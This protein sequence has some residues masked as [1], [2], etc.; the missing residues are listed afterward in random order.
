MLQRIGIALLLTSI[1]FILF[2]QVGFCQYPLRWDALH[3]FL[4][5]RHN[6]GES[7]R[8]GSLPLWSAYQYLGFP[9][10]ADPEVGAF[11]PPVWLL[12]GLFGYDFYTLHVEWMFHVIIA[13][14]GMYQL[15]KSLGHSFVIRL[16][17]AISFLASGMYVSNAQNFIYLI[18]I[19]W[20]PLLLYHLRMLSHDLK[21]K[22]VAAIVVV[23]YMMITG[24]YPGITI[25][26]FYC[27][28][29]YGLY[30]LIYHWTTQGTSMIK[31]WSVLGLGVLVVCSAALVSVAQFLSYLSRADGLQANRI[32]ENPLPLKGYISFILPWT[33]GTMENFDWG[34]DLTMINSYVGLIMIIAV[35]SFVFEKPQH[36]RQW[37]MLVSL[38]I[39][40]LIAL[41]EATPLRMW[42][43][44]LPG[45]SLFRHPSIFRFF[46][47]FLLV[48]LGA[49]QLQQ[50]R[51]ET[52]IKGALLI[53]PIIAVILL[54]HWSEFESNALQHLIA[55]WKNPVDHSGVSV[56]SRAVLNGLIALPL[57]FAA[58]IFIKKRMWYGLLTLVVVDLFLATQVNI[59]TMTVYTFPFAESQ[60]KMAQLPQG[61]SPY[62]G[63]LIAH[64]SSDHDSLRIPGI[65]ENQNILQKMPAYDGYN[66]FILKGF[67][68]FE[69]DPSF[70]AEMNHALI[71]TYDSTAVSNWDLMPNQIAGDIAPGAATEVI[72]LQNIHPNWSAKVNGQTLNIEAYK[73]AMMKVSVPSSEELRHIE[74]TYDSKLIRY[75]FYLSILGL[76]TCAAVILKPQNS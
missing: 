36:R 34:S 48:V 57:I 35:V 27:L 32:L 22:H 5:W 63:E 76:I 2:W 44:H 38:I 54:I 52:W 26:A 42:I 50:S 31:Y 29:V 40:L 68:Q 9:L 45:L 51:R 33:A 56:W 55:E 1:A 12:G 25:I 13:G 7:L 62:K 24:S 14:W 30:I 67:D 20:F 37:W 61:S 16:I 41:G 17:A 21:W 18:G 8:E 70:M 11:Y 72:L 23:L 60:E 39:L 75:L 19:S 43:S 64:I 69:K 53:M 58:A 15:S 71:Y 3:C 73:D 28:L 6:V 65:I 47:L 10:H 59:S 4:T 49:E 74:F 66:S 46:A